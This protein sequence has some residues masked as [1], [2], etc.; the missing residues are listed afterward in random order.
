[1][2]QVSETQ[3]T[4][5]SWAQTESG[6]KDIEEQATTSK[7]D[8]L[9]LLVTQLQ[10]QDPLNP[11][12]NQEFSA[13]LAQFSSLE[14]L[15][16]MNET[17]SSNLSSTKQLGQLINNSVAA[18]FIGKDIRAVGNQV[19]YDGEN[20][21][22]LQFHLEA[23]SSETTVHVYDSTGEEILSLDLGGRPAG[24]TDLNWDGVDSEGNQ[25]SSGI[26]Y[27]EVEATDSEGEALN[28]TTFMTGQVTG[29][30]YVDNQAYLL[31]G[32]KQVALE[33]VFD[34]LDPNA[35]METDTE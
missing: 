7:D 22:T 2:M 6:V 31:M 5:P 16:E 26:F 25:R 8:F 21:A 33:N 27:F 1:M 12:D 18:G 20:D 17:L 29:V 14:Q 4:L 11:A 10:N 23:A 13:Q 19:F 34:V 15:T 24:Q 9:K 3:T 35:L 28:T 30:R 32:E